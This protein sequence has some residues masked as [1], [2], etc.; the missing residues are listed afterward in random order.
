[1]DLELLEALALSADRSA[2]LAQLLPGSEDHDYYRALDAQHRGALDE[3][4]AVLQSW[5][6]RHGH[7]P[8]YD[9]LRAR[10]L[11]YR[12][13]GSPPQE[14]EPV[15]DWLEVSHWHE[16]G[17]EVSIEDVDP[18]R[19]SRL[20]DG[21]FDPV[22]LLRRAAEADA[23]LAQ[24]TDEGISELVEWQL[25]PARRRVLLGRLGHTPQAE[26]VGLV[27]DDLAQRGSVGFGALAI[28][29]ELTL[30]QLHELAGLRPE[31]RG[32]AGWVAAVVTRM[33]PPA[34]V[35]LEL[36]R[37]ARAAYLEE[38]WRFAG[39][40]PPASNSLKAHVLWHL[41]DTARQRGAGLDR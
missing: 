29:R 26:V 35:D 30:D 36:D 24:V 22:A 1:M 3:A 8:G 41:L 13:T 11:L 9:R 4:E 15:R 10:Q 33:R 39:E 18:S 21:A 12:V 34:A 17:A 23:S 5:P 2:A 25:E 14:A 38:L 28:H 32:H 6:E 19:P 37:D 20:A 31:L 16:A 27:A 40:L 7:T